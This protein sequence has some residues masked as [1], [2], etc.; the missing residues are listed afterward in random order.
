MAWP[1][2]A[3]PE[4][5]RLSSLAAL[6][7]KACPPYCCSDLVWEGKKMRPRL[8]AAIALPAPCGFRQARYAFCDNLEGQTSRFRHID[9]WSR[10]PA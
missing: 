7:Q 3:S 10:P 1:R 2:R 8:V 6:H 4:S 5:C 9:A